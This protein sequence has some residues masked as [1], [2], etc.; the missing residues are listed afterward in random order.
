MGWA[1]ATDGFLAYD[2]ENLGEDGHGIIRDHDELSFVSYVEGAQTDLE[3][4][5]FFDDNGPNSEGD[6]VLDNQDSQWAK[7]GVWQDLDQDGETDAGEFTSLDDWNITSISLTSDDVEE[8]IGSNHVFGTGSYTLT[9]GGT[10]DFYDASL[11]TSQ[12]GYKTKTDGSFE[13]QAEYGSDI[14]LD[15]RFSDLNADLGQLGYFAG[16]GFDGTDILSSGQSSDTLLDGGEGNDSLTGGA[17]ND[18]LLGGSGVDVLNAGAGDDVLFMDADDLTLGSVSGGDGFDIG[19]LETD[20]A[21]P[22]NVTIDLKTL[23]LEAFVAAGGADDLSSSFAATDKTD[24]QGIDAYLDGGSGNDTLTVSGA[25]D[26]VLGGGNGDDTLTGGSGNDTLAGGVG[27][28]QLTGGQGNDTY[29]FGWGYGSDTIDN[30]D[31]DSTN[32]N[33]IVYL[34]SY[35]GRFDTQFARSGNDLTLTLSASTTTDTLTVSDWFT[36]ATKQIDYF[37]FSGLGSSYAFVADD[38]A[39]V[40]Q[41]QTDDHYLFWGLGGADSLTGN[42]GHDILVGGEGGDVLDG[43]LGSDTASY[44]DST[45]GVSVDLSANTTSGGT[46]Q[47]DTIANIENVYGSAHA[48]TLTGDAGANILTGDGGDDVLTGNAGDDTLIGGAGADSIDG[49]AGTDYVL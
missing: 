21:T 41:A 4:L 19:F 33:D 12:I 38:T 14:Y 28:D 5:K 25:T 31:I 44:Q 46:A 10:R 42:A 23:G 1:A 39:N 24:S 16:F 18:W 48:D 13:L 7:F 35:V 27:D 43:G 30:T 37:Y 8:A 34:T 6:G 22:D 49:G 3:G 17:G 9:G 15:G 20:E 36:D 47:G 32:A 2:K 26:A 29:F 40:Y 11:A 45:A